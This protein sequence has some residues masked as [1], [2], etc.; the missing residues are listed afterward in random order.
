MVEWQKIYAR[1][2]P[3]CGAMDGLII[4]GA[5]GRPVVLSR[6]RHRSAAYP[7][8]HLDYLNDALATAQRET[9]TDVVEPILRVPIGG[10]DWGGSDEEDDG[11][12]EEQEEYEEDSGEEEDDE[13]VWSSE[14]PREASV[15]AISNTSVLCHIKAG[16]LRILCPV[17]REIDLLIPFAF[18][19]CVVSVLLEYLV[20]ADDESQLTEQLVRE[21]FDVVYQL[22]EEMLDGEGNVLLTEINSLKDVVL[23]PSLLARLIETVGIGSHSERSRT[24]LSSPVPWR[25]PNSKYARNE[26]Y[27]DLV[28]TLDGI[29]N[30]QG[31]P[32]ALDL[33]GHLLCNAKLSG[34]PA[35]RVSFNKPSLLLDMALHHCASISAWDT[36]K[37]LYFVPPDGITKVAEYRLAPSAGISANSPFLR[38]SAATDASPELP[39]FIEVSCNPSSLGS[40][41]SISVYSCVPDKHDLEDILL[42]WDLSPS[43]Q[44]IDVSTSERSSSIHIPSSATSLSGGP[45]DTRGL[46]GCQTNS[47]VVFDREK[48]S[49]RWIIPKLPSGIMLILSGF[50]LST[51]PTSTPSYALDVKFSAVGMS[52]SGVRINS[53][54][55]DNVPYIPSKAVRSILRGCIEWRR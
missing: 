37:Q 7:L 9:G 30:A 53:V 1:D 55:I 36:Q 29:V 39:L 28:E 20:G 17:S 42:E 23:P 16:K 24:S 54:G 6:F 49:L 43:A 51:D 46:P 12:E 32:V 27:F 31:G 25:R 22:L 5:S 40:D 38:R 15:P 35:L 2:F 11:E 14:P 4:L 44:G 52:R 10:S 8:L 45:P 47:T 3:L 26:V 19:R 33:W 34:T 50:I 13:N 18:M 21:H 48:H 41:I